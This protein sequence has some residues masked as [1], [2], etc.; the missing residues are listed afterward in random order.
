[1]DVENNKD[2]FDLSERCPKCGGWDFNVLLLGTPTTPAD[3]HKIHFRCINCNAKTEVTVRR[4][5]FRR[6]E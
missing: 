2:V 6:Y 4:A 3:I 1:M 5:A